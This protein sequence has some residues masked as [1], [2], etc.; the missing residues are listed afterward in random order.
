VL[1][2]SKV[3]ESLLH[4]STLAGL[5]ERPSYLQSNLGES[6]LM[7]WN[8]PAARPPSEIMGGAQSLSQS[9]E[10]S[11]NTICKSVIGPAS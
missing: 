9:H 3:D 5:T 6:T 10:I 1:Y 2:T 11:H 8:H 7:N 4:Q